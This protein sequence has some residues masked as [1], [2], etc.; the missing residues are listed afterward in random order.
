MFLIRV[1]EFH[2]VS[3]STFNNC[4]GG[5]GSFFGSGGNATGFFNDCVGGEN[6]FGGGKWYSFWYI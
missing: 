1:W 2:G 4:K 5:E 6:C 3:T